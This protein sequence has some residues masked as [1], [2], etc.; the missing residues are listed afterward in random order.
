MNTKEQ[1]QKIPLSIRKMY[2]IT[3]SNSMIH[4]HIP[5]YINIKVDK[6]FKVENKDGTTDIINKNVC[7]SLWDKKQI[8]HTT[9]YY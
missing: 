9:V 6:D 5:A 3:Q 7:V 1:Y 8:M 4:V 2:R